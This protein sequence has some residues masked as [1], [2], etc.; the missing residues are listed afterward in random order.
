MKEK[1]LKYGHFLDIDDPS[2]LTSWYGDKEVTVYKKVKT[3]KNPQG[4]YIQYPYV[5]ALIRITW[6]FKYIMGKRGHIDI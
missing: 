3:W 2:I 6:F 4:Y 1:K 5:Q